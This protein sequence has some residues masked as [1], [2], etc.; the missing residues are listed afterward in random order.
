MEVAEARGGTVAKGPL[1][2][3][4]VRFPEDASRDFV[5]LELELRPARP[6]R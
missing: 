6:A 1:R 3:V 2:T 5:P 4:T